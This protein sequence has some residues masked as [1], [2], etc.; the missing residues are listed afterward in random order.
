[1][2]HAWIYV[3]IQLILLLTAIIIIIGIALR[4][5]GFSNWELQCGLA[6]LTITLLLEIVL[7]GITFARIFKATREMRRRDNSFK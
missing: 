3:L 5:C 6:I 4:D 7:A 2:S 1:M